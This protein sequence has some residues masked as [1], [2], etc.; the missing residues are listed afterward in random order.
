[1]FP[2]RVKKLWLNSNE[3]GVYLAACD[4]GWLVR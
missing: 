2:D 4:Y 1:M 3:V